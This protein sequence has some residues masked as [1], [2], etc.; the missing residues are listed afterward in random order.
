MLSFS[1]TRRNYIPVRYISTFLMCFLP[2]NSTH[3]LS[4]QKQYHRVK[5]YYYYLFIFPCISIHLALNDLPII[6]NFNPDRHK[7][8]WC[9][10]S[11]QMH[12][13]YMINR[14]IIR[15]FWHFGYLRL[16]LQLWLL[17]IILQGP[18][19][20]LNLRLLI[21]KF[22]ESNIIF[23]ENKIIFSASLKYNFTL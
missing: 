14:V 15:G 16:V 23:E 1:R 12:V 20:I 8:S 2:C 21:S 18:S 5:H 3:L 4:L 7:F 9:F 6:V 10:Q 13:L 22:L 17:T 11:F 19:N